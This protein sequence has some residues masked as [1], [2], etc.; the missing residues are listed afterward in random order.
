[1]SRIPA[2]YSPEA[3][4]FF[5][6]LSPKGLKEFSKSINRLQTGVASLP[7]SYLDQFITSSVR[8]ER[9]STGGFEVAAAVILCPELRQP[10]RTFPGPRKYIL[11]R[12]LSLSLTAGSCSIEKYINI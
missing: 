7:E 6:I 9:E 1:M 11:P 3:P 2:C 5:D 12:P 4:C 8:V 10:P